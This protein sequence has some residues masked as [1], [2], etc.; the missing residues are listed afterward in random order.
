MADHELTKNMYCFTEHVISEGSA[1]MDDPPLKKQKND[2]VALKVKVLKETKIIPKIIFEKEQFQK[3]VLQLSNRTKIDVEM[4]QSMTRD[5]RLY[6]KQVK[7]I[8]EKEN[9]YEQVSF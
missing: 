5:Y 8:I 9:F 6:T 7:E 1:I 2:A 3:F 4:K